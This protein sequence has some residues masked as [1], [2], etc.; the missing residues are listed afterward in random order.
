V[1]AGSWVVL[2]N[3]GCGGFVAHLDGRV[4]DLHFSSAWQPSRFSYLVEEGAL[5][6]NL[7]LVH[8]WA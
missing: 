2:A 7:F 5:T 4:F 6:I 3:W 1:I 8:A